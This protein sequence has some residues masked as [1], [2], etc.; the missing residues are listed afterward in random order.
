VI[1]AFKKNELLKFQMVTN[2]ENAPEGSELW[3]SSMTG[4]KQDD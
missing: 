3:K 2:P 4:D 1:A